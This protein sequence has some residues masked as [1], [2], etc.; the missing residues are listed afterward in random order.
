MIE[1]DLIVIIWSFGDEVQKLGLNAKV[2][3]RAFAI[4][5]VTRRLVDEK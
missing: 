4:L 3:N 5:P 2:S 1:K